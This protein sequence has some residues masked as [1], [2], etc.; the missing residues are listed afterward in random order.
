MLTVES[1]GFIIMTSRSKSLPGHDAPLKYFRNT[2]QGKFTKH[3]WEKWNTEIAGVGALVSHA[4]AIQ[5]RD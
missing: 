5:S 3:V 4:I 1:T 2:I